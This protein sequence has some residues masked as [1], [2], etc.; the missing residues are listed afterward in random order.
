MQASTF[1]ALVSFA[2]SVAAGAAV[3]IWPEKTIASIIFLLSLAV[4]VLA[5]FWWVVSN[6]KF[7][8]PFSRRDSRQPADQANYNKQVV[9]I[10]DLLRPGTPMIADKRFT[11]CVIL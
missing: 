11:D 10:V 5:T 1:G 4:L 9:R 2:V 8:W 3:V 7:Q 6:Y